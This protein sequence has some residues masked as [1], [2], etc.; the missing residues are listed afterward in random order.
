V[1]VTK[2]RDGAVGGNKQRQYIESIRV[3]R[4]SR[5]APGPTAAAS[6]TSFAI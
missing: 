3:T 4:R 1:V 2:F 5:C 6:S